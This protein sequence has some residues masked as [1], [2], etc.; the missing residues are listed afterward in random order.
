MPESSSISK[1]RLLARNLSS[2]A[3]PRV[4]ARASL[5]MDSRPDTG[6]SG[7]CSRACFRVS[8]TPAMEAM[9]VEMPERC[10]EAVLPLGHRT[11][12]RTTP[13]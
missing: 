1:P 10:L 6:P 11:T 4:S 12:W 5:S 7:G 8:E 3:R 9:G 2:P 13:L